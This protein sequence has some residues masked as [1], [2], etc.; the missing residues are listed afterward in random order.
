MCLSPT[1]RESPTVIS[2]L[3]CMA[4]NPALSIVSHA[5]QT[6]Q[7]PA[8]YAQEVIALQRD[9]IDFSINGLR[10]QSGK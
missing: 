7:L 1:V 6:T 4:A 9:G 2:R 3:G 8:L 5:G 10:H